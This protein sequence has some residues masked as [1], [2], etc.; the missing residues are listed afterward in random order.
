MPKRNIES[1]LD[2][3]YLDEIL[4]SFSKATGLHIEAVNR[5]GETLAILGNKSRSDFCQFI[6][7]HSKGEKKC[8]DSY[9][10]ATLEAA[11]W[12]VDPYGIESMLE[13]DRKSQKLPKGG[14]PNGKKQFALRCA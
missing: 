13:I 9:K 8:L 3:K 4:G 10:E 14:Y 1:F 7:C 11:K 6:R 5:K 2:P 12:R